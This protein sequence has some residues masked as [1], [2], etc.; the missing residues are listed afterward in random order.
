MLHF[1]REIMPTPIGDMIILTDQDERL[2]AL[3]WVDYET[4]LERLLARHYGQDGVTLVDATRPS[5]ARTAMEAYFAGDIAAIDT[6]EVET[7]GTPFQRSVWKALRG[8]APGGTISYSQL[9]TRVDRPEAVRAVGTANGANPIGIVVPCHR[10]VGSTGALTG[11][12]GGLER[13]K[14]LLRH[15]GA[16]A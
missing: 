3:D 14:W 15:E 13:K 16:L 6:I 1:N 10:I 7:S 12:A 4:R 8:V 11:Y 5:K 9:A 2:R